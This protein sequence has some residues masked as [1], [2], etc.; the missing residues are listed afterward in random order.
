MGT[1]VNTLIIWHKF[2]I[3]LVRCTKLMCHVYQYLIQPCIFSIAEVYLFGNHQ[4]GEKKILPF[5]KTKCS[6]YF[7]GNNTTFD[8]VSIC[9]IP[10]KIQMFIPTLSITLLDLAKVQGDMKHSTPLPE[11]SY[12]QKS[13]RML[14][15]V[16]GRWYQLC[17]RKVFIE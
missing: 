7:V 5:P 13:Y 1:I 17:K 8:N 3:W 16:W 10:G 15:R 6:F 12:N 2:I 4:C 11:M 9:K 14:R